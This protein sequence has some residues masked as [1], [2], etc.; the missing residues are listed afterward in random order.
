MS[1]N[2]SERQSNVRKRRKMNGR[3]W[4]HRNR[5]N[6]EWCHCVMCGIPKTERSIQIEILHLVLS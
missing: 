5:Q 6:K 2:N 1:E 4:H 3:H